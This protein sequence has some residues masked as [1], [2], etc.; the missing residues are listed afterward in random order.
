MQNIK[1]NNPCRRL[2]KTPVISREERKLSKY[3]KGK[4]I[5]VTGYRGL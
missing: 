2:R 4:A 5:L 1:L 3:K